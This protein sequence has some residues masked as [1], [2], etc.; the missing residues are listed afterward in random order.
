MQGNVAYE[1]S[2]KSKT[3]ASASWV[4]NNIGTGW[5]WSNDFK[6]VVQEIVN[7]RAWRQNNYILLLLFNGKSLDFYQRDSNAANGAQLEVSWEIGQ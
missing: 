2:S 6:N 7:R 5:P 3:T 4:Q 1:L